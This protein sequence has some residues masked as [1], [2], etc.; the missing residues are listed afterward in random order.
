MYLVNRIMLNMSFSNMFQL[1]TPDV[2]MNGNASFHLILYTLDISSFDYFVSI[3]L[4]MNRV[5]CSKRI[6]Y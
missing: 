5:F 3:W 4:L 6:K 1:M 2:V